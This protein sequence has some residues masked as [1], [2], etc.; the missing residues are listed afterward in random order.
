MRLL[1]VEDERIVASFIER[2]VEAAH[3]S[4]DVEQDG[5]AALKRLKPRSLK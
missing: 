4:V 5:E 2:G 3:Y 1:V